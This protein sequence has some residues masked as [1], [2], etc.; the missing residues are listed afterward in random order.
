MSQ[1]FPISISHLPP[2]PSVPASDQCIRGRFWWSSGTVLITLL[3]RHEKILKN[4]FFIAT[5]QKIEHEDVGVVNGP[6]FCADNLDSIIIGSFE[7]YNA[8]RRPC[9]QV[10]SHYPHTTVSTYLR[11]RKNYRRGS[12]AGVNSGESGTKLEGKNQ[13]FSMH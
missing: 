9:V 10:F 8:Y 4:S 12:V 3:R 1:D 11:G 7:A 6:F 5:P 2:P 13:S